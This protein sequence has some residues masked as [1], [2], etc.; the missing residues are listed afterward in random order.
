[1]EKARKVLYLI[2]GILKIVAGAF[3]V[4]LSLLIFLI[5]DIVETVFKDAIESMQNMFTQMAEINNEYQYLVDASIDQQIEFIMKIC[6]IFA[7]VLLVLGLIFILL[8]VINI[9]FFKRTGYIMNERKKAIWLFVASLL[10]A[11]L[12]V[13]TVLTAV[14]TFLHSKKKTTEPEYNIESFQV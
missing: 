13:S 7:V 11:L 3:G 1:M 12:T 6:T 14:A 4:L 10:F 8:G 9:K 2:A 5:K